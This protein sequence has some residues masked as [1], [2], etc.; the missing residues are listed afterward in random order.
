MNRAVAV[1][2]YETELLD[3]YGN[4]REMEKIGH[5]NQGIAQMIDPRGHVGW[6]WWALSAAAVGIGLAAGTKHTKTGVAI[7]TL[8]ATQLL[9]CGWA[10]A[11]SRAQPSWN[12]AWQWRN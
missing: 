12:R 4:M 5:Q 3:L 10:W 9:S 6:G 8:G 11:K 2:H 7:A 1:G